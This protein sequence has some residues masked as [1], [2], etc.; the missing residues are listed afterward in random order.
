MK[1]RSV[2]V[3]G[4]KTSASLEDAFWT[5]FKQIAAAHGVT[6]A[7][8]VEAVAAKG[9]EQNLSSAIRVFMLE[10]YARENRHEITDSIGAK[11]SL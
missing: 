7:A 4:R 8:L 3:N 6:V 11:S 9:I 10:Y 1:K 5:R 2:V